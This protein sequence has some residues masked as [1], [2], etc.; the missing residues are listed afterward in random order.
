MMSTT[1]FATSTF[2]NIPPDAPAEDVAVLTARLNRA[3][4][5][6]SEDTGIPPT[7]LKISSLGT[8]PSNSS[9]SDTQAQSTPDSEPSVEQ[10]AEPFQSKQPLASFDRLVLPEEILEDILLS[11][12]S[13]LPHVEAKLIEW[14]IKKIDPFSPRVA[15]N[16]Y[17][18]PGTGKTMAAH[19]I[20]TYLQR[21]I[22]ETKYGDLASMYHGEAVKNIT[23]LFHAAERDNAVLFI[24]EAD[25]LISSRLSGASQGA[26]RTINNMVNQFLACLDRF[27]GVVIFASNLAQ[28]YD[29]AVETRV[30]HIQFSM[31]DE[32]ARAQI[33]AAH[34]PD[35]LPF[36]ATVCPHALAKVDDVC[37]RDIRMAVISAMNQAARQDKEAVEL[38]DLLAAIQRLKQNRIQPHQAS[39]PAT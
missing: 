9:T 5:E 22:L 11:V 3:F 39:Q 7:K 37:G 15:L 30:R 2:I 35:E 10:R 17:G 6:F 20:A 24:D 23:A 13:K 25:S 38:S 36:A 21:P 34:L 19:A 33:W 4:H 1:T 27:S 32:A 18:P 16:F 14:G 12:D 28:D 26:E 29:K 31:P 8:A